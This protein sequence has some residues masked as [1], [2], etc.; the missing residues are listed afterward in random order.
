MLALTIP[1]DA[2]TGEAV[3]MEATHQLVAQGEFLAEEGAVALHALILLAGALAA[4]V[5]VEK[6]GCGFTDE[7]HNKKKSSWR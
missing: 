5:V 4:Q 6:S 7:R 3:P 2:V 1:L